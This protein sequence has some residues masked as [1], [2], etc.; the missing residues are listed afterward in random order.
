MRKLALTSAISIALAMS[1][2]ASAQTPAS[3]QAAPAAAAPAPKQPP[4]A[5]AAPQT[6][7]PITATGP[8]AAETEKPLKKRARQGVPSHADARACLEFQTNLQVIKCAEKYRWA[9]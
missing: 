2:C 5:A 8:A 7:A 4:A 1:W 3:K 9:S 6:P